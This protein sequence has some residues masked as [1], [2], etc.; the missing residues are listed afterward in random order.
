MH[1]KPL[2]S[3]ILN[4]LLVFYSIAEKKKTDIFYIPQL[5]QSIKAY[6]NFSFSQLVGFFLYLFES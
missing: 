5:P 6:L 4:K 2:F 1:E 3:I